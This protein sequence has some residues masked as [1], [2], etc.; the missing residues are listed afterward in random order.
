MHADGTNQ[1][2]LT[3]APASRATPVWSPDGTKIAFSRQV[4]DLSDIFVM[5]ADG[6]GAVNLTNTA[7][8][9]DCTPSW[10]RT[11]RR[12]CSQRGVAT[13]DTTSSR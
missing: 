1:T 11:G 8:T 4:G 2:Q 13:A 10:R 5:N 9:D 3:T 6:S 12:S 7:A